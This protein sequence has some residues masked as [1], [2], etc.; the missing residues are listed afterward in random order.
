MNGYLEEQ[1][2]EISEELSEE[3]IEEE[4][5]EEE[6]PRDSE[7]PEEIKS[8]ALIAHDNKKE[9]LLEWVKE[10]KDILKHYKLYATGNTGTQIIEEVGLKVHC[11]RSGPH[12]GDM[13]IGGL[14]AEHKLNYLIFFWDPLEAHPHDVDVKALLRVAVVYDIPI[15]CNRSTADYII[16]SNLFHK[17][18]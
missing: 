4:K 5:P 8:L 16:T 2:K 3:K 17:N 14:I 15:A 1:N 6:T 9:S 7:S 10:N 13:Q 18:K 11:L 12:G